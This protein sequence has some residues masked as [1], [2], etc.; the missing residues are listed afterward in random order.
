MENQT[1]DYGEAVPNQSEVLNKVILL[2][3]RIVGLVVAIM[4][5]LVATMLLMAV[6]A[7]IA[8]GITKIGVIGLSTLL[9]FV[10]WILVKVGKVTP[11][12]LWVFFSRGCM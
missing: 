1:D 6:R 4:A 9:G 5:V 12:N 11:S 7:F 10:L 2:V 8:F 3:A